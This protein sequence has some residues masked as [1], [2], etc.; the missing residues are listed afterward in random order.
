[1][2][3]MGN[4]NDNEDEDDDED[5]EEGEQNDGQQISLQDQRR[6]QSMKAGGPQH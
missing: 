4:E 5:D 2:N 6:M 1:M 3:S